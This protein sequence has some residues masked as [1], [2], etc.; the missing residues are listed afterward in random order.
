MNDS[1]A[2]VI[3]EASETK[4]DFSKDT[5]STV[6]STLKVPAMA[7]NVVI[8]AKYT[9]DDVVDEYMPT[10]VASRS[11]SVIKDSKVGFRPRNPTTALT[12]KS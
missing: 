12:N 10:P 7:A 9:G 11:V 4:P 1:L 2:L 6:S 5:D 8:Y 3:A